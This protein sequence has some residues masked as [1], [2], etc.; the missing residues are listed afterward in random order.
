[1]ML[2]NDT[3]AKNVK[4]PQIVF[5]KVN[6]AKLI[7]SED[8]SPAASEV[9]VRTV[10]STISSGTERANI[11]GDPN[12]TIASDEHAKAVFPRHS[13]YSSSGIV[14]ETG[15]AVW[16]VKVGDRVAMYWSRHS[17]YNI[18]PENNV[19]K[20]G[21]DAVSLEAAALCHIGNFPLAA[22]RKTRLEIGEPAMVMG[23]GTLGLLAVTYLR[24]AGAVPVI[25]AD[26][27]ESRRRK[28]LRFGADYA[29]DPTAEGFAERVRE[30]SGGGIHAAIEVTGLGIGL[31]ECLD[32]MARFGRVA[33]LGCTRDKN[34][35]VDYYRKVHGPGISL[36]GAH[37]LARP[38][39]DSAPGYFTHRDD[40]KTQLALVASGRVDLE[41]MIDETHSPLSCGEIYHRLFFEKDFP[42]FVQ[43]DW[44]KV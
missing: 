5:T 15:N 22:I 44:R 10:F 21:S 20:I 12:V 14:V 8:R 19:V 33:L 11:T 17:L 43:F 9:K 28:A 27:L 42:T 29:L 35:T 31:N 6:T 3:E 38:E 24:A 34:F 13:G 16:S 1:M 4:N 32:C 36:I 2:T 18:L 37:T 25:A 7:D 40:I 30:L 26:P 41:A 23:L 39:H